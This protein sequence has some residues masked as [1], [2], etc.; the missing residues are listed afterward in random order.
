MQTILHLLLQ[1]RL[2][3]SLEEVPFW[4]HCLEAALSYTE[5]HYK[6]VELLYESAAI[7]EYCQG[8]VQL[9]DGEVR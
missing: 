2:P 5:R 3:E 7:L 1:T 8:A 4:Q 6:R 9:G